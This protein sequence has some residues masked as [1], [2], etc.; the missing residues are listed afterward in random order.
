MEIYN[1]PEISGLIGPELPDH[2]FPDGIVL[3][4]EKQSILFIER[5]P[6]LGVLVGRRPGLL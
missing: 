1:Y 3:S 5:Q 6:V 2:I 4:L